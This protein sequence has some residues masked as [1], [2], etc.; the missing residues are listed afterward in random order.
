LRR[1]TGDSTARCGHGSCRRP[2]AGVGESAEARQ[3]S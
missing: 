3:R 1:W 2:N